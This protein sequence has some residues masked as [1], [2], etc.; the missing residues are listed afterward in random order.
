RDGVRARTPWRAWRSFRGVEMVAGLDEGYRALW[1]GHHDERGD[2]LHWSRAETLDAWRR[3][4]RG[5]VPVGEVRAP[6]A[7][8]TIDEH[9]F[10][11]ALEGVSAPARRHLV[12]AWADAAVYGQAARDAQQSLDD[13]YPELRGARGVREPSLTLSDARMT[14]R[15][16]ERGA[17]PLGR[18]ELGLWSQR[19]RELEM[20]R[21]ERSR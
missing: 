4:L 18:A 7:R 2:K 10:G 13:L 17:R 1:A 14:G 3:D 20:S 12:A 15:V 5:V 8:D 9:A 16:R 19:S 6:P 11:A 21:S